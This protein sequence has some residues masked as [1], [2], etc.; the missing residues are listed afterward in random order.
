MTALLSIAHCAR[1]AKSCMIRSQYQQ[2]MDYGGLAT[3]V[4]ATTAHGLCEECAA[5][6]WLFSVDGFRWG[7]MDSPELLC[8]DAVQVELSRVLGWMH[9]ALGRLDW[10]KLLD[11]WD[12]PWP[13]DWALPNDG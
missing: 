5:H 2:A 4:P 3:L 12:L 11:Q 7:L 8:L 6:W 9:P 13:D 1:C 10:A